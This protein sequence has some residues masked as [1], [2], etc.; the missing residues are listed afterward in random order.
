MCNEYITWES[1]WEIISAL[2]TRESAWIIWESVWII[3]NEYITWE[4]LN[5]TCEN[6]S[7]LII[8]ES[9]W[10]I[11]S[12]KLYNMR[13]CLN[14]MQRVYNLSSAEGRGTCFWRSLGGG[15]KTPP[16]AFGTAEGIGSR[17][18]RSVF[19]L[20]GNTALCFRHCRR[21]RVTVLERNGWNEL[22]TKRNVYKE[23]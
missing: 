6:E 1:V 20:G 9:V 17:F 11:M 15:G 2:P 12:N 21:H 3:C 22:I 4:C 23:L 19:F 8:W 18:W 10:T 13:E 16:Y 14:N 7:A 5:I